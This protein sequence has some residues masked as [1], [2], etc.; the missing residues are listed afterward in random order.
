LTAT[1]QSQK[2]ES[3]FNNIEKIVVGKRHVI[4]KMLVAMLAGG[5]ILFEDVPGVGKTLLVKAL[6]RSI[7]VDFKRIQF[8]PDLL[9]TDV[10]GVSIYNQ[11][12]SEFE[13]KPGPILTNILLADE[14]NR[15]SPKSQS[16]LLEAME[17]RTI[18]VDGK[19]YQLHAP[20]MV[21]A[22]QNPV[23]YEGTFPLPEAQM[24]RF[25]LKLHLGYPD[26]TSELEMLSRIHVTQNVDQLHPVCTI[27]D[28][29]QLQ[30]TVGR[31]YVDDLI[32][33]YIVDICQKTRVHKDVLLGVSPRGTVALFRAA[34][35]FAFLKQRDY[36]VPDDIKTLAFD[37]LCHRIILKSEAR[38]EGT[39]VT[40]VI[41][42]IMERVS[43]PVMK[44]EKRMG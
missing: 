41:H 17:E 12:S 18:T 22:T 29:L 38:I 20:F 15:T 39:D 31:I 4:E 13:F 43:V 33:E 14:I 10:I 21:M 24:D 42:E 11:K 6:A 2:I 34:Q 23:E 26:K 16:A 36:V 32:K 27:E 19:T 44:S 30:E 3:I 40:D 1:I 28:I 5:H 35:A 8:T 9:P 25:M 7:G 37:A